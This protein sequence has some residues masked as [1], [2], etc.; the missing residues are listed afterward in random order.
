ME[1][2][3]VP[4]IL[5]S[6]K[7]ILRARNVTY[8]QVAS[9]LGVHEATVKRYLNG[10][11][12]PL[13]TLERICRVAGIRLIDLTEAALLDS[14]PRGSAVTLAQE[15]ILVADRFRAFVFYLLQCGWT[16]PRIRKEF[17]MDEAELDELLLVLDRA[18]LIRLMPDSR[19]RVLV[20]RRP[21][22]GEQ[23]P[24]RRSIDA[25]VNDNFSG[26]HLASL[27]DYE[28]ETIKIGMRSVAMLRSLMREL[29]DAA[30][31]AARRDRHLPPEQLEWVAIFSAIR[32]IEPPTGARRR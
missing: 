29:A 6:L 7:G 3:D 1:E 17:G 4:K 22:W 10:G 25:W 27:T 31:E 32:P 12:L 16:L 2:H 5:H 19:V 13:T 11:V 21:E 23:G 8:A 15:A 26:E 9:E 30:G 18:G 28:V 20:S 14:E 24:A